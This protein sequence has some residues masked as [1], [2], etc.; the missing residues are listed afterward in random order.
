[1][2]YYPLSVLMLAGLRDILVITTQSDAPAFRGLL[3]DGRQWGV[4]IRYAVQPQ[5]GGLAQAFLIGR[6]FI[7]GEPCALVLGDNIFFGHDLEAKLVRAVERTA[8]ATVFGYHL[9][10]PQRYSVGACVAKST[11]GSN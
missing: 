11:A 1:M 7:G 9:R 5:P 6:D 2:T 8:G 10:D 3:H 4:S